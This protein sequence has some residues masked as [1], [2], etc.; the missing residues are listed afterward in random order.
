MFLIF[1]I[2]LNTL[3]CAGNRA[4]AAKRFIKLTPSRTTQHTQQ[5]Q[6]HKK[7]PQKTLSPENKRKGCIYYVRRIR[8]TL[9]LVT[10][11]WRD[12]QACVSVSSSWDEF[13]E[14][15]REIKRSRVRDL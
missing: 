14:Q 15:F 12:A 10:N 7:Q 9:L 1:I 4:R 6:Q 2:G 13:K 3:S 5:Q 8:L 11:A